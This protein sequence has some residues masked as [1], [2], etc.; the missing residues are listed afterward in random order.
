MLLLPVVRK[1]EP[2]ADNER[3]LLENFVDCVTTGPSDVPAGGN[4]CMEDQCAGN[5]PVHTYPDVCKVSINT[6]DKYT[7]H[8]RPL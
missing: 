4:I 8:L 2:A 6:R 3:Q 1:A 7:I 5:G